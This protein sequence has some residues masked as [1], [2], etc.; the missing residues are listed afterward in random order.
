MQ[1]KMQPPIIQQYNNIIEQSTTV[2]EVTYGMNE[3]CQV[4]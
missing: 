2:I 1:I 4:H 3:M